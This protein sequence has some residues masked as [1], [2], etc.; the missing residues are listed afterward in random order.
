[1]LSPLLGSMAAQLL[2]VKAVR[3]YQV[4]AGG[5]GKEARGSKV[6]G[7]ERGRRRSCWASRRCACIRRRYA[8]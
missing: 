7:G 2:G 1:M 6:G 8:G 3:V 4:G 5:A